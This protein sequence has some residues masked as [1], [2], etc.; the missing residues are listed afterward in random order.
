[1]KVSTYYSNKEVVPQA[2]APT[3]IV[4]CNDYEV[5]HWK[6]EESKQNSDSAV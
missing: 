5:L 1:M 6:S 3:M 4:N 2:K